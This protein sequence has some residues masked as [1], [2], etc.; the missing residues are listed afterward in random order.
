MHTSIPNYRYVIDYFD[1]IYINLFEYWSHRLNLKE[2]FTKFV[3]IYIKTYMVLHVF[4]I[5]AWIYISKLPK[6]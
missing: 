6:E 3:H 5:F 4:G 2:W 1:V